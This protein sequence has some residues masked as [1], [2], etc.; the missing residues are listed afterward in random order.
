[1]KR[2]LALHFVSTLILL[3]LIILFK[4]WFNLSYWPLVVGGIVGTFLPDV[5]HLIYVYFT[6]P[7]ELTSQRVVSLVGRSEVSRTLSLLYETRGERR[8]LIFHSFYFQL[9][10][11]VLTFL[12]ISSSGSVFGRG[13]VAAFSLHL[14]VDEFVDLRALG[15]LENWFSQV[16]I[17]L[18]SQKANLYLAVNA[19][20]LLIFVVLL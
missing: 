2:E 3:T 10:F 20:T 13:L 9:L 17:F 11:W 7:Q 6:S 1:M 16:G 15:N 12:V 19:V 18:D 4:R 5:D 14:I 8:N